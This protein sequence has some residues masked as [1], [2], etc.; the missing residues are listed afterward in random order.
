[1]NPIIVKHSTACKC[2]RWDAG[3]HI[4]LSEHR[5]VV[6]KLLAKYTRAQLDGIIQKMPPNKKSADTVIH[7]CVP[8]PSKKPT[9]TY[10]D[11][12]VALYIAIGLNHTKQTLAEKAREI[13]EQVAF[14]DSVLSDI[15]RT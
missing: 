6:D 4:A 9:A 5:E 1:M 7:G 13:N 11:E 10:K 3:Y 2:H 15:E 8:C 14:V 12:E